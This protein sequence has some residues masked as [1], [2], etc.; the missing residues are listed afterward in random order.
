MLEADLKQMVADRWISL[1]ETTRQVLG[2]NKAVKVELE[3]AWV[4]E[5]L[6]GRVHGLEHDNALL[7]E[8]IQDGAEKTS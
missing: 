3:R 7:H 6:M 5:Y 4:H 2:R 1:D 8:I